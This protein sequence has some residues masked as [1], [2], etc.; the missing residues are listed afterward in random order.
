MNKTQTNTSFVMIWVVEVLGAVS[1]LHTGAVC[2][3]EAA[4][5]ALSADGRML[6]R[7]GPIPGTAFSMDTRLWHRTW[8]AAA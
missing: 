7:Q 2:W 6:F 3:K 5:C 1:M 4:A 8:I